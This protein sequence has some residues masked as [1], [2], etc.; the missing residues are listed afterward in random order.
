MD[1]WIRLRE[2]NTATAFGPAASH[3]L[4]RHR[5]NLDEICHNWKRQA[6]IDRMFDQVGYVRNVYYL[7]DDNG[8]VRAAGKE[9]SH[10]ESYLQDGWT[11]LIRES[12]E[13][14]E[15]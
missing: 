8:A 1:N 5:E 15:A 6:K 14:V 13:Q 7:L 9:L 10:A 3:I 4:L 12:L 2:D 11:I